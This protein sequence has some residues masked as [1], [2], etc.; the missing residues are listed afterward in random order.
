MFV[1][2]SAIR[3]VMQRALPLL[4]LSV[5]NPNDISLL[6]ASMRSSLSDLHSILASYR[7][8]EAREEE[9]YLLLQQQLEETQS[10]QASLQR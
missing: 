3:N 2:L 9:V 1:S 6:A 7:E 10:V 4:S 5:N 8:H